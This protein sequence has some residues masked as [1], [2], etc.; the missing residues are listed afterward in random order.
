MNMPI[1]IKSAAQPASAPNEDKASLPASIILGNIAGRALRAP[2]QIAATGLGMSLKRTPTL[3]GEAEVAD[4]LLRRYSPGVA[5]IGDTADAAAHMAR[6]LPQSLREPLTDAL[7]GYL[8]KVGPH[9]NPSTKMI[10]NVGGKGSQALGEALSKSP[11]VI[12]HEL[13][14]ALNHKLL[15]RLYPP[16]MAASRYSMMTALPIGIMGYLR[17]RDSDRNKANKWRNASLAIGGAGTAATL[18]DEGT[19]SLRA[20]KMLKSLNPGKA[21]LKANRTRLGK[22]FGTYATIGTIPLALAGGLYSLDVMAYKRRQDA[23]R[24]AAD[25]DMR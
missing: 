23:M 16:L 22:A 25:P 9:Y 7:E 11:G 10:Y 19:A 1:I 17:H 2:G 24:Q 13:G 21:I 20:M 15:G 14:H 12:G 3:S 6:K 18:L 5:E 8:D 4:Q